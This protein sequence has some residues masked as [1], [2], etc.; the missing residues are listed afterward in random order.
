M[1]TKPKGTNDILP[2]DSYRWHHLEEKI[3]EITRCFGYR[4]IRTPIFES[5]ELFVRGVGDGTDIVEKE[6]YTFDDRGNRSMTLRPEG[7][8]SAVR[9][10]I[11]HGL[12]KQEERCKLYYVGP[13]FRYERP[14]AGR[15][16]Q[17]YQFGLEIFGESSPWA[18]VEIFSLINN[19]YKSLGLQNL[20]ININSVGCRECRVHYMESL[21]KF[22]EINL[23][24]LCED[25][26]RRY[27]KN[28]LRTLDC[29]NE[30]CHELLLEAPQ[31]LSYICDDCKAHFEG[32][33]HGLDILGI[34]YEIAPSLVRGL[35]Y[36]TKTVFEFVSSS[37]GAQN[38]VG[39]GGRYDNLIKELGG[40]D[41]PAVGFAAGIERIL[42]TM[43]ADEVVIP[44]SDLIELRVIAL[45]EKSLEVSFRL[46]QDLRKMGLKVDMDFR[47]K[48]LKAQL[49]SSDKR[50][51]LFALIIGEN[52]LRERKAK[53]K[54]LNHK[55]EFDVQLD[56][57]ALICKLIRG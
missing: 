42:L 45:D 39:G 6:M 30:G 26:N 2:G 52:E 1:I 35:D 54:D 20:S 12:D 9:S 31:S 36:Y 40:P 37:L 24:S 41:I 25:C 49:R 51:E 15:F 50:R 53:L 32:V 47:G 17:H 23:K 46:T 28:P 48:S 5:T 57:L 16:R 27:H 43:D 8:A 19:L 33:R 4:E 55:K 21:K 56:D 44:D 22:L 29:K 10:Y 13:M 14:Q 11:E 7:T 34:K 3:R 38:A 18:D